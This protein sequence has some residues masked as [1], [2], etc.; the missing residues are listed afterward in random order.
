MVLYGGVSLCI[1]MH[2]TTKEINRLVSASAALANGEASANASEEVY[3]ELLGWLA[4]RDGVRTDVIAGTSA[5]GINGVY[6]AKALA[7]NLDQDNLRDL[8]LERGDLDVLLWGPSFVKWRA[9]ARVRRPAARE[10][11]RLSDRLAGVRRRPLGVQGTLNAAR[12]SRAAPVGV[13]AGA[14]RRGELA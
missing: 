10:G 7:R 5:G 12:R 14:L 8:W 2:G 11:V 6:L 13:L 4:E 9:P 1:Y 3:S